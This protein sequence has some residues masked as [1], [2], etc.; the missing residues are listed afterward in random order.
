MH[1]Y[2]I[3]WQESGDTQHLCK[4]IPTFMLIRHHS[5]CQ[6]TTFQCKL[7]PGTLIKTKPKYLVCGSQACVRFITACMCV[8]VCVDCG[9]VALSTSS[10]EDFV[11]VFECFACPTHSTLIQIVPRKKK[12]S[13]VSH[14]RKLNHK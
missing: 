1:V 14:W 12:A 3:I 2:L 9:L 13:P 10:E 4:S 6:S 8:D 7:E 11:R 5:V